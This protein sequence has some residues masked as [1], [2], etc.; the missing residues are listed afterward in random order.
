M[1]DETKYMFFLIMMKTCW[2]HIYNK[3]WDKISDIV[4][5]GI[6]SQPM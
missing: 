3:V 5:K 2:S 1:F 4:Q 6:D